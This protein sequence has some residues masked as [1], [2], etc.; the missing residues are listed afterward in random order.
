MIETRHLRAFVVLAEELH[1]GRAAERLNLAQSALSTQIMRLEDSI[2]TPLLKRGRR[3]QPAL[4]AAGQTFLLET[5]ETLE[6]LDR[7]ARIARLAGQGG[8]GRVCMGYV[9]SAAICGLVPRVLRALNSTFPL[10]DITPRL[11]ETPDQLEALADARVLFGFTRPRPTCPPGLITRVVHSENIL[12]ALP[13]SHSLTAESTLH[14]RD[15]VGQ[16]FIVPQFHERFG[17]SET[18]VHLAERGGFAV[19]PMKT[20]G[21]F[22]TALCMAAGGGGIVL[23]PASLRKLSIDGIVF[24]D[25][26]DF[27]VTV[28]LML[29]Y[30]ADTPALLVQAINAALAETE[31]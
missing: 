22:I 20:T 15:F 7:S 14:A 16:T 26:A 18:L 31:A 1:F 2:G 19:P 9:F 11:M 21:D 24:R 6:R 10:L 29:V 5:R 13:Q 30:R 8:A 27:H 17:L 12:I 25:I 28:E 3:Q 4:T 23:A